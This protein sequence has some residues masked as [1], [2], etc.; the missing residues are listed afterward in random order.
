MHKDNLKARL[1]YSTIAQLSYVVAG[2]MLADP[3][4]WLGG[5]LQI[6]A[7]G[8]LHHDAQAVRVDEGPG[9]RERAARLA[10]LAS[11]SPKVET[12][13]TRLNRVGEALDGIHSRLVSIESGTE[14][15]SVVRRVESMMGRLDEVDRDDGRLDRLED[16]LHDIVGP[17]G[18]VVD[19]N[20]RMDRLEGRAP[21]LIAALK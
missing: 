11:N 3:A 18:D 5:S 4:G 2:A 8:V 17:D 14:M 15:A 12:F 21:E 16:E 9:I 13:Q 20:E 6:A 7:H 19:L 1:A 10:G